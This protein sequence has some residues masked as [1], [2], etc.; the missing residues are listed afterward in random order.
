M[1]RD[2]DDTGLAAGVLRSVMKG[3]HVSSRTEEVRNV[4]RLKASDVCHPMRRADAQGA[5]KR[6]G[7]QCGVAH[8]LSQDSS[9]RQCKYPCGDDA[10]MG[11]V[12]TAAIK[13]QPP[14]SVGGR[15]A[16]LAAVD[17]NST[18]VAHGMGRRRTR[19]ELPSVC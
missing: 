3:R 14:G 10:G 16:G 2:R 15:F 7:R 18:A 11:T 4:K 13:R 6:R 19:K 9:A 1:R 8:W 17:G 12:R 5:G